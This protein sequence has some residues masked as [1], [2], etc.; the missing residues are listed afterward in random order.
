[1]IT[2]TSKEEEIIQQITWETSH[3]MSSERLVCALFASDHNSYMSIQRW[4][5]TR[6]HPGEW[7]VKSTTITIQQSTRNGLKKGKWEKTAEDGQP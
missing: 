6:P 3:L 4:W 5:M 2:L 7:Y 1:M